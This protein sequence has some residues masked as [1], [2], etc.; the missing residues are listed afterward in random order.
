MKPFLLWRS[1]WLVGFDELD[2]Q[3]ISLAGLLNDLNLGQVDLGD[4][5]QDVVLHLQDAPVDLDALRAATLTTPNGSVAL[6]DVADVERVTM[7]AVITR[8]D[9]QRT[10]TISVTPDSDELAARYEDFDDRGG[11]TGFNRHYF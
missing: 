3:H 6:D 10:V 2:Q 8:T 11:P 7:P 4:G 1:D 9:G 5:P